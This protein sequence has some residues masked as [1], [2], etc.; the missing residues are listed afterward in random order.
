[1]KLKFLDYF[2]IAA[3]IAQVAQPVL[4]RCIRQNLISL[5]SGKEIQP[6]VVHMEHSLLFFTSCL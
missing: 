2:F 3:Q 1:M 5:G 4:F 6:Y